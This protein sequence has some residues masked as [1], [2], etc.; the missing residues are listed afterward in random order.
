VC[1]EVLVISG[2]WIGNAR[3]VSFDFWRG[4]HEDKT[5]IHMRE[6]QKYEDLLEKL[7]RELD[8]FTTKKS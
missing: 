8:E 2:A 5:Q 1:E 4:H 3:K 6:V 7:T